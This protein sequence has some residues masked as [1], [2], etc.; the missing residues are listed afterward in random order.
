MIRTFIAVNLPQNIK[1]ALY[2]LQQDLSADKLPI[3]WVKTESIHITLKFIGEIH[4]EIVKKISDDLFTIPPICEPFTITISGTGVFPNAKRPRILWVGITEGDEILAELAKSFEEALL[5]LKIP[6]EGRP[7]RPHI[8]IGRFTL[9]RPLKNTNILSPNI[10]PP[11]TFTTDKISFMKSTLKP[12][13]A[14]YS[15]IAENLLTL[16]KNN[17]IRK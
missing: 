3:R 11:Q 9:Q 8:T 4:E 15:T 10:F 16:V 17:I 1:D 14:E 2:K 12:S 7:F 5:P 6:K 13:G